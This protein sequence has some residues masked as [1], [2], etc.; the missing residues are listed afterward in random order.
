MDRTTALRWRSSR[1]RYN[2]HPNLS[3]FSY[4][5]TGLLTGQMV[6]TTTSALKR[7]E[8]MGLCP[9]GPCCNLSWDVLTILMGDGKSTGSHQASPTAS[10]TDFDLFHFKRFPKMVSP[11]LWLDGPETGATSTGNLV[12]LIDLI[13][14]LSRT[15]MPWMGRHNTPWILTELPQFLKREELPRITVT[16]AP[17]SKRAR[18]G[19]LL[20]GI[21]WTIRVVYVWLSPGSGTSSRELPSS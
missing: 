7:S 6:G 5:Q 8:V 15:Y 12:N 9:A 11:C 20:C 3:A 4:G 17:V 18:K 14:T 16:C 19:W 13:I 1:V 21:Q 10:A 2:L